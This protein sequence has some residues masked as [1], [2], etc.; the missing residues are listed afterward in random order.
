MG[1]HKGEGTIW[2]FPS[3]QRYFLIMQ[4]YR[5]SLI[6]FLCIKSLRITLCVQSKDSLYL[7]E[8]PSKI[9]LFE[10]SLKLL[11]S[12]PLELFE[13]KSHHKQKE[14]A[15][16]SAT[17]WIQLQP[18]KA[19]ASASGTRQSVKKHTIFSRFRVG[20]KGGSVSRIFVSDGSTWKMPSPWMISRAPR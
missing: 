8:H 18:Y 2:L 5:G 12:K 15:S 19:S 7:N 11:K 6:T 9:V 10:H 1:M 16:K 20:F 4:N 13:V 17:L 14:A 3:Q